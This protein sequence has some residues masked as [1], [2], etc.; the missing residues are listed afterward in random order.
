MQHLGEFLKSERERKGIRLSDIASVTKIQIHNLKLLE[1]GNWKALP[2][3]PFVKGFLTAYCKYVGLN[4]S[5][6]YQRYLEETQP[7]LSTLTSEAS[8]PE[9][10]TSESPL[11]EVIT[12]PKVLQIKPIL[13]SL[14][15]VLFL[16]G[17]LWLI[18]VGKSNP[19]PTVG[20]VAVTAEVPQLP[21][22]GTPQ[23]NPVQSVEAPREV[24]SAPE[25]APAVISNP[26]PTPASP[27][28]NGHELEV[29][30]KERTWVKIVIDDAPPVNM[31]LNPQEKTKFNA[32]EKIKLVLGNSTGSEVFHNGSL[33]EGKKYS[34]TI[35]FYIFPVGSKFPQDKPRQLS[36]ESMGQQESESLPDTIP[37]TNPE[38]IPQ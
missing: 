31:H 12:Q 11:A 21:A 4:S 7:A 18:Q 24:A 8:T 1:D 15:A 28:T 17:S 22:E 14:F 26:E 6:I 19:E 32:K 36:T 27:P 20:P 5:E 23:S 16:G 9:V 37:E 29:N 38:S 34:G 30:P 13:I 10:Q 3:K 25:A 33:T 35:R 2:A